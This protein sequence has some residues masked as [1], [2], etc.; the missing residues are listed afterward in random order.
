MEALNL[1]EMSDFQRLAYADFLI[2]RLLE[3]YGSHD[4]YI[5][6]DIACTLERHLKVF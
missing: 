1:H 4:V 2:E 3:K 6:Y 5:M